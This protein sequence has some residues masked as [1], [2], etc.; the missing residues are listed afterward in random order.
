M[1]IIFL[2]C[3]FVNVF[4]HGRKL[5]F[6][7][8]Q[9]ECRKAVIRMTDQID[10]GQI[11]VEA[12]DNNMDCVIAFAQHCFDGVSLVIEEIA[13]E[14]RGTYDEDEFDG[15]YDSVYFKSNM[16]QTQPQCGCQTD[17]D[18]SCLNAPDVNFITQQP[19]VYR[20]AG[21]E[22]AMKIQTDDVV[23]GGSLTVNWTCI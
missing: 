20:L 12:T 17:P 3:S 18:Y 13:L 14:D 23:R 1:L 16:Q 10:H 8:R 5:R 4:V 22:H 21:A 15:C 11:R 2:I 9:P 19:L 6:G 7:R